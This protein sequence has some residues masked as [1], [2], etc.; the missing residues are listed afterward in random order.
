MGVV[1][2]SVFGQPN[3]S[4]AR[5]PQNIPA[6]VTISG[7][8]AT[9][10]FTGTV[11]G[12]THAKYDLAGVSMS[13]VGIDSVSNVRAECF[14]AASTSVAN[15]QVDVVAVPVQLIGNA[16][17]KPANGDTLTLKIQLMDSY[18]AVIATSNELTITAVVE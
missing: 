17:N 14:N 1:N 3:G 18:G 8:S 7:N 16:D 11:A 2:G 12:G 5:P 10:T 6:E 13:I 9:L 4:V 15:V